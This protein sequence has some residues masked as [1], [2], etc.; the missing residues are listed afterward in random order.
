MKVGRM[1]DPVD[2]DSYLGITPPTFIL[3]S[4]A[5]E[6]GGLATYKYRLAFQ[7]L[8]PRLSRHLGCGNVGLFA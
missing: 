7:R 4:E 8:E 2:K 6:F 3:P 5:P 1:K